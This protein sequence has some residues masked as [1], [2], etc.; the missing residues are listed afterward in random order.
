[1]L[2]ISSLTLI[3]IRIPLGHVIYPPN[4]QELSIVLFKTLHGIIPC[5]VGYL[6][7]LHTLQTSP[8][9][10]KTYQEN[11]HESRTAR[12]LTEQSEGCARVAHMTHHDDQCPNQHR[13]Q[14]PSR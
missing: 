6:L 10:V 8:G 3:P 9:H 2:A 7:V 14:E 5:L 13:L 11:F 12:N 4:R 1:C